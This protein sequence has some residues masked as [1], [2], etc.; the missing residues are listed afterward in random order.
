MWSIVCLF[1]KPDFRNT[2]LSL[3]LL[4][5]AIKY[6]DSEGSEI[7]EGY[8]ESDKEGQL[9][10]MVSYRFMGYESTFLKK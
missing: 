1:I 4:K 7:L 3:Q 2:G 9:N 6:A 8:P 5:K 10:F